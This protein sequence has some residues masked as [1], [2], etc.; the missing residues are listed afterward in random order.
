MSAEA[1]HVESQH[2][3]LKQRYH[4]AGAVGVSTCTSFKEILGC[5]GSVQYND[6]LAKNV[7]RKNI[8][9]RPCQ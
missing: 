4:M 1:L 7:E 9:Y 8:P 2:L 6:N 5:F 3:H